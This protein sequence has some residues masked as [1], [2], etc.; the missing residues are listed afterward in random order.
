MA[1]LVDAL[2]S[3]TS[4]RKAVQ[5]RV[6]F[7]APLLLLSMEIS[8]FSKSIKHLIVES[9]RVD[10][11]GLGTFVAEMMPA[12]FSDKRTTI[13]PPYRRLIFRKGKVSLKEGMDLFNCISTENGWTT[14]QSQ[15][16][17]SDCVSTICSQLSIDKVCKLPELGTIKATS[18]DDYVFIS[19]EDPDI[20]PEGLGLEPICIKLL[21]EDKKA[22]NEEAATPVQPEDNDSL[23]KPN[24]KY[25]EKEIE[26]ISFDDDFDDEVDST[27]RS[28]W[29]R[30]K[31]SSSDRDDS[32]KPAKKSA[33][34]VKADMERHKEEVRA[35]KERIEQEI[36]EAKRLEK[37]EKERLAEEKLEERR[38]EQ[39]EKERLAEEKRAE[40]KRLAE[41][42]RES[43]RSRRDT[44][45]DED[46]DV[47]FGETSKRYSGRK[48]KHTDAMFDDDDDFIRA[49]RSSM[50][51]P[52]WLQIL[53]TVI[54]I[55][56]IVII[57]IAFLYIL[58]DK[59]PFAG[60]AIS[61]LDHVADLLLYSKEELEL[62]GR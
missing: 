27:P 53:I 25:M 52:L 46:F 33:F 14:E 5:V 16:E 38:K 22:G 42:K 49:D 1:E 15:K 41:E 56:V 8:L 7:R 2:V 23:N 39:E 18:Q 51:R 10:L 48:S 6:L 61:A 9:D 12:S 35:E 24:T 54:L 31:R 29:R 34:E 57:V 37:E 44:E 50:T 11:P 28:L 13:N 17:V 20:F 60:K 32:D 30:S 3:G 36:Q 58:R 45:D 55:V 19:D 21:N 62:L 43:A 26:N 59:V 4:S 47:D 40:R